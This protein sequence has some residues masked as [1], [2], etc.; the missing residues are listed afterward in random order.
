MR[1]VRGGP[2]ATALL[3]DAI[4][5]EPPELFHPTVWMGRCVSAFE[6]WALKTKDPRGQRVAG[7]LLAVSLPAFVFVLVRGMVAVLPRGLRLPVEAA[8]ISTAV[9]M[10]GLAEA[11]GAVEGEL[12][13]EDLVAARARVGEFVGRDT[14][15]LSAP[16]VARAAVESVAENTS[17]G[18]VAPMLY[19]ALFGAP[20]ALCYKAINTLDS[21]VGYREP[22]YTHLGL[23]PACLDDLANLVPSRLTALTVAFLS[24]PQALRAARRFGPLTSSPNAGWV[25]AAFAGALDL[26]LGGANSYGGVTR[27]GPTLGDGRPPAMDDIRRAVGLMRRCCVFLAAAFALAALAGKGLRG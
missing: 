11:A 16:E 26:R 18:V 10:R 7:A 25:E 3:L 6:K 20:G 15:S 17:D 5:G 23:A 9:S 4:Y 27:E 1:L 13:N 2:V 19:G 22:P 8:V 14:E 12:R 24:G 21:M